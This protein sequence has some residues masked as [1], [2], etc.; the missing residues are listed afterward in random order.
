[1]KSFATTANF[2][3]L[4]VHFSTPL[5]TSPLCRYYT[6]TSLLVREVPGQRGGLGEGYNSLIYWVLW[7]C[8]LK[9][10]LAKSS[11]HPFRPRLFNITDFCH[12]DLMHPLKNF[13]TPLSRPRKSASNRAPH[14]LMPALYTTQVKMSDRSS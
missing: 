11:R 7:R 10:L 3:A 2:S 5:T 1:M 13:Y 8:P 9:S 6:R 4:D 12:Y 14:L